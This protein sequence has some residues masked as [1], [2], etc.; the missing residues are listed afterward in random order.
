MLYRAII[1]DDEHLIRSSLTKKVNELGS[2]FVAGTADNGIKCLQWLDEWHA[3]I[4]ITDV[5][6]PHMDGLELLKHI[7][8]KFPWMISIVIS[9]YE[10][11]VYVRSSMQLKAID[12]VLKPIER[13]ALQ[14]AIN[15]AVSKLLE[16]RRHA[17][18]SIVL[19]KLQYHDKQLNQWIE[20]VQTLQSE[21]M[22][23]LIMET[24]TMF[25]QWVG[26]D[27]YILGDIAIVWIELILE[28]ISK[29]KGVYWLPQLPHAGMVKESISVNQRRF[30]F[31]LIAVGY[32]EQGTQQIF[33]AMQAI[34][35]QVLHPSV[36]KA[37][38][39]L[40]EHYN[41]KISLQEVADAVAMSKTYLAHLFKQETGETIWGYLIDIRMKHAREL[42]LNSNLKSYEIAHK[43]GYENSIRFSRLFKDTYGL[44]PVE[45]KKRLI[46]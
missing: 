39:Y 25:E 16:S 27:Y 10:E 7:N 17:A 46:Q 32:L 3:D 22:Y 5:Q 30:V 11:F 6:M 40:Q 29:E 31:R 43:V 20:L 12:Y 19:K 35:P 18:M 28:R 26:N 4:C 14:E 21:Q 23:V 41:Q 9:S 44:N 24:L 38:L 8:E 36:E 1:V 2:I 33:E 34:R 13:N 37:K 15:H 45:Y 42:L